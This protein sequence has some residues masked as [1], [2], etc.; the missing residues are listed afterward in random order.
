MAQSPFSFLSLGTQRVFYFLS[1]SHQG[2]QQKV[3]IFRVGG[4]SS[5]LWTGTHFL[6]LKISFPSGMGG[7]LYVF[8]DFIPPQ[9]HLE[10]P[11]NTS[12]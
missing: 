6:S 5:G 12:D 3:K 4:K 2:S 9:M 7:G 1:V 8:P 10:R 11:K